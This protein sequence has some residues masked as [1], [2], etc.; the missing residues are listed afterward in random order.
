[1]LQEYNAILIGSFPLQVKIGADWADSDLDIL[2]HPDTELLVGAWL[3]Q[4]LEYR[5]KRVI[6]VSAWENGDYNRM[7]RYIRRVRFFDDVTE[8]GRPQI[9]I[10]VPRGEP[11]DPDL[12]IKFIQAFDFRT[13]GWYG[14]GDGQVVL[15]DEAMDPE[16]FERRELE[17]NMPVI[18][19]QNMEEWVRFARRL[20]KYMDRGFRL[21]PEQHMWMLAY[22]VAPCRWSPHG[23]ATMRDVYEIL[24]TSVFHL[25]EEE[26]SVVL[27]K[28]PLVPYFR[29]FN[30]NLPTERG[31]NPPGKAFYPI[32][33][34]IVD[35]EENMI[36]FW[37]DG[38]EQATCFKHDEEIHNLGSMSMPWF[39]G[40]RRVGQ[41]HLF[42]L[43]THG[44]ELTV[45]YRQLLDV[46]Q[47]FR[48][49]NAPDDHLYWIILGEAVYYDETMKVDDETAE[50][51]DE[52]ETAPSPPEPRIVYPIQSL[53]ISPLTPV[54]PA[55]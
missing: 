36:L 48:W 51:D 13:L 45:S 17:I 21:N 14:T 31:Q 20:R 28:P 33:R 46:L 23:Q 49:G 18:H 26:R 15:G 55:F 47:E 19:E 11:D 12:F 42:T 52:D 38:D 29:I 9:Q 32:T 43:P 39:R 53:R 50:V 4:H 8:G 3:L 30:T 5:V 6:D 37:P 34:T 54:I 41:S 1:M 44:G 22:F 35:V 27:F 24:G 40:T 25:S 10:I 16:M 2:V 7:R